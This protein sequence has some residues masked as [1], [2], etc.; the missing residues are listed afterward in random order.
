[1]MNMGS[2][3][4]RPFGNHCRLRLV[5]HPETIILSN[6]PTPISKPLVSQSHPHTMPNEKQAL[7]RWEGPA[8]SNT[9]G[10]PVEAVEE[11]ID[12]GQW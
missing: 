11:E 8:G 3:Q 2:R 9:E 12:H 5:F 1:M 6:A 10:Y 4:R 7:R